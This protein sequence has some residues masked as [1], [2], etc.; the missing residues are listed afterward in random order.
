MAKL[1]DQTISFLYQKQRSDNQRTVIVFQKKEPK[2]I[3][4]TDIEIECPTKLITKIDQTNSYENLL[5]IMKTIS[6]SDIRTS[7]E[8]YG[9]KGD[10]KQDI[11]IDIHELTL[12]LALYQFYNKYTPDHENLRK[13]LRH[14]YQPTMCCI[15]W[16]QDLYIVQFSMPD[17]YEISQLSALLDK[18]YNDFHQF[19]KP[20]QHKNFLFFIQTISRCNRWDYTVFP[21]KKTS[22]TTWKPH[23]I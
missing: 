11:C 22:V 4:F 19:W 6:L 9:R 12:F 10:K 21:D 14:P 13:Y 18:A 1:F 20:N 15:T 8:P 17:N 3:H 5:N 2:R 23:E 16:N 7:Y